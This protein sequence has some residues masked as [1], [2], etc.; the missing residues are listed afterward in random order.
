MIYLFYCWLAALNLGCTARRTLRS[1]RNCNLRCYLNPGTQ[2]AENTTQGNL[3]S[4]SHCM[5][6]YSGFMKL[7]AQNVTHLGSES[8]KHIPQNSNWT[9]KKFP[10]ASENGS[11][12]SN[13]GGLPV[14]TYPSNLYSVYPL[15]YGNHLK[16]EEMQP[17]F[18]LFSRSI[19]NKVEPA[20]M[21]FSHSLFSS[22]ADYSN[23]MNQTDVGS[24]SNNPHEIS[25]DRSILAVGSSFNTLPGR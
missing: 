11:F 15:Y 7:T 16:C 5:A 13:N 22:E 23:K 12:P 8:L 18:G 25:C 4:N 1:Q 10:F 24:T 21:S 17:G 19:S 14:E 2:E 20:K 3:T 9:P 6:S